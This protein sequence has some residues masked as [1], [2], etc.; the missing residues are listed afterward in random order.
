MTTIR[1]RRTAVLA[2]L[3]TGALAARAEMARG[4]AIGD[5]LVMQDIKMKSVDGREVSIADAAGPKGTLVLFS[6]NACPWVKAW[7]ERIA[8]LGNQMRKDGIG[9]IALNANDPRIYAEDG[10]EK[11]QARAKGRGFE[12][13][14]V[15]D[16]GSKVARAFGASR[17]PEAYLFDAKGK[18]VYH[19][20]IDDNAQQPDKVKDHYLRDA[21]QALLAGKAIAQAETKSLGCSI[22]LYE[23]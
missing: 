7:E 5:A 14:Y 22:K 12:F 4:L 10:Y 20:T 6:C 8:A 11:M 1:I 23:E 15:V 3:L 19:G 18:L 16:A 21:A 2:L 13:P 17:T 9:V